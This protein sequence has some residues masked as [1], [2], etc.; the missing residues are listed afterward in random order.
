MRY[1]SWLFVGSWPLF[2]A[3]FIASD[4]RWAANIFYQLAF[5]TP[6][7]LPCDAMSRNW[8]LEIPK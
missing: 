7:I 5:V 4:Q 6:G 8:F 2:V 1:P 3:F